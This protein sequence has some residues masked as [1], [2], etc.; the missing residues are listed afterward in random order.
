VHHRKPYDALVYQA[1]NEGPDKAR[2]DRRERRK[3]KAKGAVGKVEKP[4]AL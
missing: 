3:L 2:D 1:R 4:R